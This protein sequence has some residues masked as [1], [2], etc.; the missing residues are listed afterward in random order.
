MSRQVC[1]EVCVEV[2][3]DRE[4]RRRLGSAHWPRL[5]PDA[6][7]P[8]ECGVSQEREGGVSASGATTENRTDTGASS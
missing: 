7:P 6:L 4:Q 1:L 3:I 2:A 8:T 5:T